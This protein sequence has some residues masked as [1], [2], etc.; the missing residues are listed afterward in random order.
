MVVVMTTFISRS[1]FSQSASLHT[2]HWLYCQFLINQKEFQPRLLTRLPPSDEIALRNKA[3]TKE[4]KHVKRRPIKTV[5]RASWTEDMCVWV[6]H[7]LTHASYPD[8]NKPHW[9]ERLVSEKIFYS[10][11][12]IYLYQ[13]LILRSIMTPF[14]TIQFIMRR[15]MC[16]VNLSLCKI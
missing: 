11:C 10:F 6:C 15:I 5:K 1:Q 8:R 7:L 2:S 16:M 12:S 9:N 4:E 14:H 3:G 13:L